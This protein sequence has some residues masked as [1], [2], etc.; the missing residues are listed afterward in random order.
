[1]DVDAPAVMLGPDLPQNSTTVYALCREMQTG[2]LSSPRILTTKHFLRRH[3]TAITTLVHFEVKCYKTHEDLFA[4][5]NA[6]AERQTPPVSIGLLQCGI[7][8]ELLIIHMYTDLPRRL[9]LLTWV[10]I[11]YKKSYGRTIMPFIMTE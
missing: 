8:Q 7:Q 11:P 2:A 4:E 9:E 1:M 10:Y 6:K 5:K 3:S